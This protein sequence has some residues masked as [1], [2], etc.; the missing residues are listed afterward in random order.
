MIIRKAK[1]ED[2]VD[3]IPLARTANDMHYDNRPDKF[4]KKEAD[5]YFMLLKGLIENSYDNVL[6]AVE[7]DKIIGYINYTIIERK[8][9]VAY[10]NQFFIE[11]EYRKHGYGKALMDEVEKDAHKNKCDKI[12]LNCWSFNENALDFY[13]HIGYK[14]QRVILEKEI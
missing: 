11:E 1:V 4:N 3:M 2:V 7:N 10:V 9:K 14:N 6:L 5:S 13:Y 12:E 8:D